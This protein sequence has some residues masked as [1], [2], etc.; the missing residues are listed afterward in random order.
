M[1]GAGKHQALVFVHSRKE[2]AKTARALRDKAVAEGS[3]SRLM[4]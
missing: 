4:K 3:L 2:T 1:A